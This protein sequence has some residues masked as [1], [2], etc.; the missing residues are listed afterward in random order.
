MFQRHKIVAILPRGEAIRNF[1]YTGA[2]EELS[3]GADVT[4][5]S[6]VPNQQ[7]LDY[8][9]ERYDLVIPL[10]EHR[11]RWV[12]RSI[13]EELDV[14][15]GRWLWSRGA[16]ARWQ[17]RDQE[18]KT[19]ERW[20][21][22]TGKKL[23]CYPFANRPG[24]EVLS[25][26]ERLAS[27]WFRATDE[28]VRLFH[29]LK[30]ALVF[31]GSQVHNYVALPAV[32]AAKELGI[33]TAT[34][35]F[36]WDN[37]TSQGRIYP[38]SDYYI[39]WNEKLRDDLLEIYGSMRA[40]Q[41]LVTGTPQFDFHFRPQFYWSREEFFARIGADPNRPV[42]LYSTG[43][44][45]H[46]IGEPW[47]V[48]RIADMLLEMTELGPPQLLV[49][50][51]PKGPQGCFDDLKRRRKDI[52]FPPVPWEQ[53]W[54]TPTMEDSFLLTN[55]LRHA[56]IGINIA[57]T[58]SLELCM[59]D[60]PVINVSFPPP[61]LN[62]TTEFDYTRYYEFEHYRPVVASGAIDIAYSQDDLREKIRNALRNP[63]ERAQQR[64]A[65]LKSLFGNSLD[66][67]SSSRVAQALMQL[68]H[69]Q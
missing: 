67:K 16:Q 9:R 4:L 24:L 14:A 40:E 38:Q 13:R 46:V 56:A 61:H 3:T 45:N 52:L 6:V 21:K 57:S 11:D 41:V 34:F 48:E 44:A 31:N 59:F 53:T 10:R 32:H 37:L 28:Y 25:G 26:L 17:W 63:Q 54:L 66:G 35:V 49:R 19:L 7:L 64:A 51:L 62:Q 30:P 2:L 27:Q 60:K 69:A 15:H 18:A 22:R 23:L 55:T 65:L 43:M 58:I 12:V 68:V 5:L 8:L 50:I 33:P 36:S 1:V 42:V 39:V 20:L 29:K 47:V